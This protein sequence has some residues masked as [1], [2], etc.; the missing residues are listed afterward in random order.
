MPGSSLWWPPGKVSGSYLSPYLD[1]KDVVHL[2][3]RGA[4][5]DEPGPGIDV[6][7]SLTRQEKRV[8]E[9]I[10]GLSPLSPIGR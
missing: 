1:A 4:H 2:S 9:D 5:T 8:H 6:R 3:S 7:V 10:L